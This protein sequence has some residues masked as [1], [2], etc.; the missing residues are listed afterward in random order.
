MSLF[1]SRFRTLVV[2]WSQYQ[3]AP[4]DP[5]LVTVLAHARRRLDEARNDLAHVRHEL[6]IG[7]ESRSSHLVGPGLAVDAEDLR[8]LRVQRTIS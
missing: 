7:P 3:A 8:R 1:D 5:E 6:D 2:R 4:R